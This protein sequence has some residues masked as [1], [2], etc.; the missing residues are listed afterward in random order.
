MEMLLESYKHFNPEL[1]CAAQEKLVRSLAIK[2]S[3]KAGTQLSDREMQSLI[4]DLSACAQP[5]LSISGQ[6]VY[7]LMRPEYLEKLF[8]N[9]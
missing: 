2:Q 1:K 6:P 3:T 9:G 5:N 8:R 4:R 7:V